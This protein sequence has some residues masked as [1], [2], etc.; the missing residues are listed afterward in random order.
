MHNK[1]IDNSRASMAPANDLT[2]N[3][4]MVYEDFST[5]YRAMSVYDMLA[6]ELG[7]GWLY[8]QNMW[9]FEVLERP[10]LKP[11]AVHDAEDADVIIVAAHAETDLPPAVKSWIRMWMPSKREDPAAL[12]A[13]IE[14]EAEDEGKERDFPAVSYLRSIADKV[15]M[16]FFSHVFGPS[17]DPISSEK[18]LG[19]LGV[20]YPTLAVRFNDADS[21]FKVGIHENESVGPKY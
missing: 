10:K 14:T 8:N 19:H 4:V 5:G 15:P 16:D 3:V 9:K 6:R 2:L 20:K 11:I 21:F 18:I 12:V 1:I 17:S 7:P 13:L